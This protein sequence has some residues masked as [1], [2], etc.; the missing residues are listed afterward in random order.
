MHSRPRSTTTRTLRTRIGRIG[1][2]AGLSAAVLLLA[3]APA[4]AQESGADMSY[5]LNTFSFLIWGALVM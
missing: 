4:F 2:L 1:A 3:P 5:V